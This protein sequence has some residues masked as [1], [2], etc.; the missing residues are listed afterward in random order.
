MKRY[1]ENRLTVVPAYAGVSEVRRAYETPLWILLT[2][3]AFVLLI[4]CANLAN[5]LLARASVRERE[6]ALRQALGASR[7]RLVAQ[8]MSES[9]LL[10]VAGAL[11]GSWL[12]HLLGRGIVWFLSAGG[13]HLD[14]P[15]TI[16]WHVVGFT[17]GIAVATVFLFGLVP[18]IRATRTAP[19]A[20]MRGGRGAASSA[21]RHRFRRV[22]IVFQ[23]ALSLV[24]LVGAL[25]FAH[26][27]RNLT[28]TDTGLDTHG[29]LVADIGGRLP[30][31]DARHRL[32]MFREL[33]DRIDRLPDVASAALVVYSPFGGSQ[34]N[35]DVHADNDAA[36]SGGT[37]AW[38]NRIGPDYFR[39]L[40]IPILAGRTFDQR[41]GPVAERVA[42][43]NE[44]FA[45]DIFGT[46]HAVGRRFRYEAYAGRTDPLFRVVGVVGNTKY[47]A[48]REAPRAIAFLPVAQDEDPGD[49]MSVVIRG[50]GSAGAIT[51]GVKQ[52]M[53][54]LDGRLLVEFHDLDDRIAQSVLKERLVAD[55]SECFGLLAV[56]LSMLGLYG[57]MSY[58]VAR[59]RTE[60][61]VRMALGARPGAILRMV[62]ID[63]GWLLGI[64]LAVGL[65]GSFA[66]SRYLESLL[67]NQDPND[68]TTLVLACA[69]LAVTAFVAALIPMRRAASVDPVVVLRSE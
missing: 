68:V 18:A 22:L 20:A 41:D 24:L 37:R 52:R 4:A 66:L 10:A 53:A 1:L 29:I 23:I 34:W 47:G 28:T 6:F 44:K 12:A 9:M 17:A 62:T 45:R 55:L 48:L 64:G 50:R 63:I 54:E 25:L 7:R 43:V 46:V 31:I 11:L 65:G 2:S 56:L 33:A 27:L 39:T 57:V 69:L 67:F 40:Q 61:G 19:I 51:A 30:D 14:V 8:L 58:I 59:R 38:F 13:Q 35:E 32:D 49:S 16:D 60:I 26:S 5:L 3:T 36:T 21:E 42:I 15:L